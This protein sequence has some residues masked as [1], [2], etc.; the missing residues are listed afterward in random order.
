[1]SDPEARL[2]GLGLE[3]PEWVEAVGSY[4]P[5]VRHG[6]LIH[7]SG[8][9]PRVGAV[10]EVTGTVGQD[11]DL[12]QARHAARLCALRLLSVAKRA[13]G[14]LDAVRQV[15]ELTVYVHGSTGFT[16]HSEV[17]D[18]ASDLLEHVLGD[19][20]RH[21]RAAIGVAQLPKNAAVE[22]KGIFA[23]GAG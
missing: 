21:A 10:L 13:A 20:G 2:A 5:Y 14:S 9:L 1:M 7:L 3:L 22:I 8:Q 12:E 15:V 6:D 19:R 4:R 17:A 23:L 16:Q 11:V 18:A